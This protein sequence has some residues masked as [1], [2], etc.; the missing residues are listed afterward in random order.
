M[1]ISV[2]VPKNMDT[3]K[4]KVALNLT[5][6]QII[7]FTGAALVAVPI[8][9]MTRGVVGDQVASLLLLVSA[10]PFF[11]V[12]MYE[13][14]GLT[15]EKIFYYWF[16]QNILISGIRRYSSENIYTRLEIFDQKR[17]EA[18]ELE[19]ERQDAAKRKARK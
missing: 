3:I 12:A 4:S 10:M 15:A 18:L 8:Y 6:R 1:A 5:L 19:Q 14:N 9:F 13:K 11:L 16:R 7:C 2:A 17:K